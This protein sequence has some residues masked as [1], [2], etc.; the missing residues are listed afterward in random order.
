MRRNAVGT[1]RFT[2]QVGGMCVNHEII[3]VQGII[4]NVI[5]EADLHQFLQC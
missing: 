2:V 5:I 3:T 4:I 1:V